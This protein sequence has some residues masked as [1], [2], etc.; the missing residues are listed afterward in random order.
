[1]TKSLHKSQ[2]NEH[3]KGWVFRQLQKTGRDG[4]D[5]TWRSR[6]FQVRTAAVEKL[7]CWRLTAVYGGQIVMMIAL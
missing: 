1:M 4:A 7:V 2:G 6:A 3:L 5:V